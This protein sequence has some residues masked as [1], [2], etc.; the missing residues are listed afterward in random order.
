MYQHANI[1]L[2]EL[3][4]VQLADGKVYLLCQYLVIQ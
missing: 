1:Y 3:N 2:L 4:K